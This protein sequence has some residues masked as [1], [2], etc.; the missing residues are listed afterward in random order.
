MEKSDDVKLFVGFA[1]V[2]EQQFFENYDALTEAERRRM[3]WLFFSMFCK[4]MDAQ[5]T[6]MDGIL[7][8]AKTNPSAAIHTIKYGSHLADSMQSISGQLFE[9]TRLW[10]EPNEQS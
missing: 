3:S 9:A 2:S 8:E 5:S 6:V 10:K 1:E 7:A 4:V